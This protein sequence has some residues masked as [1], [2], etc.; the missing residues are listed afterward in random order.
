MMNL[1]QLL[2]GSLADILAREAGNGTGLYL[3]RTD[4][5]W[6]AFESSAYRLKRVYPRA[7]VLPAMIPT[8]RSPFVMVFIPGEVLETKLKGVPCKR[9]STDS[10]LYAPAPALD[11]KKY[12]A[13]HARLTGALSRFPVPNKGN[14][15]NGLNP[16]LVFKRQMG[17][18][19]DDMKIFP[20]ALKYKLG[21]NAYKEFEK[22]QEFP[23]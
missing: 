4:K 7:E 15:Q 13:W 16:C 3:Y 21:M 18:Y 11:E 14:R 17:I 2:A 12:H 5:A 8:M 23:K 19:S 9:L 20:L 1:A 10:L 6:V 22:E